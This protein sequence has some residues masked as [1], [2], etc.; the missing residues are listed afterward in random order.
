MS[1]FEER[2]RAYATA[3]TDAQ[4]VYIE[5]ERRVKELKDDNAKLRDLVKD[6][7]S[8]LLNAYD[9]KEIDDYYDRMQEMGIEVKE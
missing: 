2:S 1:E 8:L 9:P 4:M 7:Y 5:A 6:L 3:Q